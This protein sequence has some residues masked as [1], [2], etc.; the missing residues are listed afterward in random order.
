[1]EVQ[2]EQVAL[3]PQPNPRKRAPRS[4]RTF[5]KTVGSPLSVCLPSP[6]HAAKLRE[7]AGRIPGT[8]IARIRRIADTV[9]PEQVG[10]LTPHGGLQRKKHNGAMRPDHLHVSFAQ[11]SAANL[12]VAPSDTAFPLASPPPPMFAPTLSGSYSGSYS[13]LP[14]DGS[15][16]ELVNIPCYVGPQGNIIPV[17]MAPFNQM[18]HMMPAPVPHAA[19]LHGPMDGAA[20]HFPPS[21]PPRMMSGMEPMDRSD[22]AEYSN[23]KMAHASIEEKINHLYGD[24]KARLMTEFALAPSGKNNK[25]KNRDLIDFYKGLH[26]DDPEQKRLKHHFETHLALLLQERH[27]SVARPCRNPAKGSTSRWVDRSI[28]SPTDDMRCGRSRRR[29]PRCAARRGRTA[30][31]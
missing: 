5:T 4:A 15:S 16:G 2:D 24:L 6:Q 8:G 31:S 21:M 3:A 11:D 23:D 27:R 29:R 30:D 22:T 26:E 19:P 14:S 12:E 7:E 18:R 1:M 17:G 20:A 28:R 9:E 25:M 10:S 13:S